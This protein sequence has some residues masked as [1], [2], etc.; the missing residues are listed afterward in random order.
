VIG[1]PNAT[2]GVLRCLLVSVAGR[3]GG[4]ERSLEILIRGLS[5]VGVRWALIHSGGVRVGECGVDVERVFRNWAFEPRRRPGVLYALRMVCRWIG[6]GLRIGWAMLRVRPDLVHANTTASMLAAVVPARLWRR[7]IVWHVRDPAPPAWLSR[8]LAKH[9]AAVIAVSRAV[10]DELVAQGVPSGRIRVIPNAVEEVGISAA[11]VTEARRR[12][13]DRL[14]L[15]DSAFVFLNVGRFVCWKKQELYLRAASRIARTCPWARFVLV[16]GEP[17]AGD[18]GCRSE[19]E[20]LILKLGLED[21]VRVL[22]WQDN[23]V[24]I[25]AGSDVLV[26]AATAEPFG[27]VLIE[28]MSVGVPVIAVAAGGP[29]DIVEPGV[30]GL[31]V[32]PDEVTAIASA[33]ERL[34]RDKVLADRLSAGG[35]ARVTA[36]LTSQ[37]N[38]RRVLEVYGEVLR[39]KRAEGY[40]RC[41]AGALFT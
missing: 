27:R 5:G 20:Q 9:A 16:G 40:K 41:S 18:P 28:A 17:T 25:L 29:L 6:C 11:E 4:A 8:W 22:D 2:T 33:M 39:P 3:A 35:Q 1:H 19:L 31:L 32:P 30:S 12:L 15:A 13:R 10:R 23:P 14:D 38:I 36:S 7:P 24:P 26:H 21:K 34:Y 37:S